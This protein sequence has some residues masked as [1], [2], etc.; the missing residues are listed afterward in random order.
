MVIIIFVDLFVYVQSSKYAKTNVTLICTM[1][2][3]NFEKYNDLA[4]LWA[5]KQVNNIIII[6][7][8]S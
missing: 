1:L 3:E 2:S 7:M 6:R 8:Q 4:L 5:N